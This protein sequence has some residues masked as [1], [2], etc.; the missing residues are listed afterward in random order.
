LAIIFS[1]VS[2]G[3]KAIEDP[4][5]TSAHTGMSMVAISSEQSLPGRFR[6]G[7]YAS[8]FAAKPRRNSPNDHFS[9]IFFYFP[10][11]QQLHE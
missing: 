5:R 4:E 9:G 8:I 10:G 2:S 6:C 7:P 1:M 3:E 11:R